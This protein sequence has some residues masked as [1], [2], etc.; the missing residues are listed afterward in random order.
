MGLSLHVS[1]KWGTGNGA[2]SES[3]VGVEP[4]AGARAGPGGLVTYCVLFR[5][6]V[7]V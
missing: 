1:Q 5:I 3:R 6:Q 2:W 4:W 7:T